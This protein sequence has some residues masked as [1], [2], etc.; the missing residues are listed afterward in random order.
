MIV[1]DRCPNPI[2]KIWNPRVNIRISSSTWN[3]PVDDRH[4]FSFECERWT[5]GKNY[6]MK[7]QIQN[8]SNG[9][10]VSITSAFV[11]LVECTNVTEGNSIV[12]RMKFLAL[13]VTDVFEIDR[14]KFTW[15]CSSSRQSSPPSQS[16]SC[17]FGELSPWVVRRLYFV[18]ELNFVI[19]T[20]QT[21][22]IV[23]SWLVVAVKFNL[24]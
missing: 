22:V 13:L 5:P 1:V 14:V 11:F 24:K 7:S 15:S 17:I 8:A 2:M 21:N 20:Y 4:D 19:Q 10:R 12:I 6:R 3:A 23:K 16:Q 9:L 18:V